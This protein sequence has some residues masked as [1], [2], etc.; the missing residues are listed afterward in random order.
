MGILKARWLKG[1]KNEVVVRSYQRNEGM[2]EG[3]MLDDDKHIVYVSRI[4]NE[5]NSTA[6]G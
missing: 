3:Q 2:K 5:E 1:L 4:K 6:E